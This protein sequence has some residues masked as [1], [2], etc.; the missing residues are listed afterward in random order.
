MTTG[1]G[2]GGR[3]PTPRGERRRAALIDAAAAVLEDA[4][5]AAVTHRA[6]AA[7]AAL[8]LA[9]T[10]YY[11]ASRGDLVTAAVERIGA[12]HREHA[13]AVLH[14]L[15]P[16]P[17][18]DEIVADVLVSLVAGADEPDPARLL[19]FYE[20]YAQAGR[21]PGLRERVGAWT[22]EL[23]DQTA[24]VLRH[25]GLPATEPLPRL[26]VAMVDGLLLAGLVGADQAALRQVRDDVRQVLGAIRVGPTG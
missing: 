18:P 23:V 8:P 1:T 4:G 15:P 13:H 5:F 9:A 16:A 17:Q 12:R 21:Q 3:T 10:T 20:R 26:L 25:Y 2:R 14:G 19:T 22:D 7:R 11:F 24:G 6:V